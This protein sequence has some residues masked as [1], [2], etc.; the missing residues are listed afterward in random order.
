MDDPTVIVVEETVIIRKKLLEDLVYRLYG[1]T[2]VHEN[3]GVIILLEVSHEVAREA[4]RI[5]WDLLIRVEQ[6]TGIS[7]RLP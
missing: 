7:R 6:E 5:N 3:G 1:Y 4:S 2:T